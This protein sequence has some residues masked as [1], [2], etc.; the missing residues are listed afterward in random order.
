MAQKSTFFAPNVHMLLLRKKMRN[1]SN[2]DLGGGRNS[3]GIVEKQEEG[4]E[5]GCIMLSLGMG[6]SLEAACKLLYIF[7]E[8]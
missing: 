6:R 3:T 7:L 2:T 1:I 4:S 8:K 5:R